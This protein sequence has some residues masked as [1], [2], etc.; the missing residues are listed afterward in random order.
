[1]SAKVSDAPEP[2]LRCHCT[3]SVPELQV[4]ATVNAADV[5]AT[6][7]MLAGCCV[8]VSTGAL[9]VTVSVALLL[10]ALPAMFVTTARKTAPLSPSTVAAIE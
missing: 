6:T 5:P 7:L 10:V 4:P 1:M 9:A 8:I 2:W 3:T